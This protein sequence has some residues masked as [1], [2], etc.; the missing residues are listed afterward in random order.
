MSERPF[1]EA[2]GKKLA[3]LSWEP[4]APLEPIPCRRKAS[5]TV[6]G[7]HYCWWHARAVRAAAVQPPVPNEA[8]Q[9]Q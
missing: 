3:V 2:L 9:G 6:N 7:H 1:C 4:G 8:E 5:E